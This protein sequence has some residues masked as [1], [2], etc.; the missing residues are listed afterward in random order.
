MKGI[1]K[2]CHLQSYLI[3]S[4]VLLLA[5]CAGPRL[6]MPT[7]NLYLDE[8]HD[9]YKDLPPSLKSTE[10]RLFYITD[11]EAENDEEGNLHYGYD[12]SP[13]L[14]FGTVVVDLGVGITWEEL[15]EA[16]RTQNRPKK[17]VLKLGA[18]KEIFRGPDL[19]IPYKEVNGRIIEQPDL[20]VQQ[21]TTRKVFRHAFTEQ[22]ALT[23]R[24]EVF[25]YVHGYNNSFKDAALVSAEFWHFLGRIGIPIIYTWPS[26]YPGPFGYTYDRESSEFTIYHLRKV[27]RFLASFPEVEKIHLIA[28]SRGTDVA[29]AAVREL[30]ISARA[31]GIDPKTKFKIHNFVLAAPDLDV[32]VAEQRLAGD[33]LGNSVNRLTIYTSSTDR[34]I[35]AAEWLFSSPRGRVGTLRMEKSSAV[36]KA[37]QEFNPKGIAIINYSP[38]A[39]APTGHYG[40]S[41]YRTAPTVSS[42]IVLM[43]RDDLDAGTPERPLKP[44]GGSF[45]SVPPGYPAAQ[46]AQ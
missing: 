25:I 7:P 36:L 39:N 10:V 34:A 46:P 31:A 42:D 17:V 30:T 12:R 13:S 41:Y 2:F 6:M 24:K 35:G 8:G 32:Q 21:K 23:P 19:P 28:H 9:R 18:I 15:L 29:T 3:F 37:L 4:L 14:A 1:S 27:L 40:H 16:S 38:A 26:G 5:G 22:L 11:R 45:W 44:L 33:K 43:L 20:L